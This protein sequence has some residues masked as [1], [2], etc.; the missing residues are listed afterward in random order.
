MQ[1]IVLRNI[2][3]CDE[4]QQQQLR[5]IRN[6]PSVRKSMYTDH[7]IGV[8]EH[9]AW[10]GRLQD[11]PKQ[12][13]FIVLNKG[14]VAGAVSIN[15]LDRRHRKSDWAFYL[16]ENH[17]GGLGA[18]LEFALI[19]YAFDDLKLEKLNCE[20]IETNPAVVRMHRRFGFKEEG[21]R[22]SNIEKDGKRIG[23]HFLGLVKTDW[24]ASR[25]T[26]EHGCKSV[27]DRFTVRI[28]ASPW[29]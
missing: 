13:V 21:F 23:V 4:A 12:I 5:L 6:R 28:E 16:D 9:R 1:T 19:N 11:D 7:E 18:A 20:V 15:D 2:A 8:E 14:E 24:L 10:L 27:L 29:R 3:D 25:K 22:R 26:V 17:R